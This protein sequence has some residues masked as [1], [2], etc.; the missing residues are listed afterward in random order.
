MPAPRKRIRILVVE[1]HASTSQAV[2]KFL[3]LNEYVAEAAF[4]VASALKLTS[5]N[6]YDLLICDLN[7]PD[8][9]GWDLVARLTRSKP[10]RAIAFSAFDAAEHITRSRDAGFADY[11]VKGSGADALLESIERVMQG[12][13]RLLGQAVK[14]VAKRRRA[15]SARGEPAT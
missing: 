6:S 14:P 12:K 3:E 5:E 10:V 9:T 2:I 11:V 15:P 1:D 4:D 7:L 13:G 8:G